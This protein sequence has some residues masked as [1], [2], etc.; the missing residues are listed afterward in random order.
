MGG[1]ADA[2]SCTRGGPIRARGAEANARTRGANDCGCSC[3]EANTV[4]E[5]GG[6]RS[7]VSTPS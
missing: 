4:E 6:T 2:A 5:E 7:S 1:H 3:I